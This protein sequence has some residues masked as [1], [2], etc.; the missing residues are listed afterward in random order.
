[1]T[2]V[3]LAG[4]CAFMTLVAVSNVAL[5]EGHD[6]VDV[7]TAVV[8]GSITA[9]ASF[10]AVLDATETVVGPGLA[11]ALVGVGGLVTGVWMIVT[12]W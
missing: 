10:W 11:L 12:H 7:G 5:E 9:L 3:L 6:G 2:P 4:F 1:M 8:V